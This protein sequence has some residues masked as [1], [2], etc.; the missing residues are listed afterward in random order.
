MRQTVTY[1]RASILDQER[2]GYSIPAQLNLLRAYAASHHFL[3]VHEFVDLETAKSTGR[4]RFGEMLRFLKQTPS[5]RTVVVEQMARF[6]RKLSACQILED[7]DVEIHLPNDDLIIR[8]ESKSHGMLVQGVQLDIPLEPIDDPVQGIQE[9]AVSDERGLLRALIDIFPDFIHVKD[10]S[11]R[12]V[13]ANRAVAELVG[14]KKPEDLFGKTDFDYFS[15]EL[16]TAYFSDDQAIVSSGRPLVDQ[17][18]RTV[19]AEGNLLWVSTSK[20][21]LRNQH[22]DVT[23]IMAISRDISRRK[24]AEDALRTE[25]ELLRTLID[26]M[27]DRIYVKDAKSRWVVANRALADLVGAKSPLDML[28]KTDFDYFPQELATAFLSDEEAVV[29]SGEALLNREERSVDAK[30]NTRWTSISKVPWRDNLGHVNGIMAIG[31]DITERKQAEEALRKSEERFRLFMNNSPTVAWIKDEEGRYVY[32]S[33]TYLQCM[34]VRAEDRLG[35]ADIEI[36]PR[37]IA[38]Q[39]RKNDQAALLAGHPIEVTEE[40]L[41]AVGNKRLWL[42]RKFPIQDASGQ[43]FVAGTGLDITEAQALASQL[44]QAKKLE[45][46]G[47]LAGGV[48]H[49]FNNLLSVIIGYSD[50]LATHPGLDEQAQKEV[51]EIRK[52]ANRAA[53]LTRQLLAFSRQQV[54][55]PKILNLN[56]VVAETEELIRRLIR[57]DVEVHTELAADLGS[58]KADPGQ[59]GQILMNLALNARDAMPRGGKLTIE[60]AEVQLDKEYARLHPPCIPGWYIVMTVTDTGVGM[61]QDT[62]AHVFEPFFTTKEVGKGTGLGLATVYGIVKQSGGHVWV[63]SE[64]GHGS[65]FKIFLPRVNRAAPSSRQISAG[66]LAPTVV[67]GSETVFVV[68]DEASVRGLICSILGQHGYTVLEATSSAHALQIAQQHPSIHLVLTDVVMPGMNGP[69]MAKKLKEIKPG[70]KVL[71]M[72]GYAGAC[73]ADRELLIQGLPLLQKPFPKTALLRKLRETLEP[74]KERLLA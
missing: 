11:G 20:I 31:H 26:N 43:I 5:C 15:K 63:D 35:K 10:G 6:Y 46:V 61:D 48:A 23:G 67:G 49:D 36:Y 38:E 30:G 53:N 73:E 55:E 64:L 41:D 39:F 7:L 34:G 9:E 21:P 65:T 18:E 66:V 45:S 4:N 71:Y 40:V 42:A 57:E 12:F 74:R 37:A 29:R 69:V 68:E 28:G 3:I 47:R 50:V 14:A 33:E 17:E 8:K 2:E 62:K 16:A 72:S 51:E 58:V 60:T 70:M 27:P 52:A 13:M 54:L 1:A 59:I 44:N 22:G 32:T 24:G 19:D 56:S 25:Q